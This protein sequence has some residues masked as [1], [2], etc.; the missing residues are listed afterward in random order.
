MRTTTAQR[1][2]TFV[3]ESQKVPTDV[4]SVVVIGVG[5]VGLPLAVRA[6]QKNLRVIGFDIDEKKVARLQSREANYITEEEQRA[7]RSLPN[8][9][10]TASES[11]IWHADCY[12]ICV[13]TPVKRDHTPDLTP[14]ENASRI[15]GA[16]MTEGALVVVE[17]TVNPGA[18]EEVALPIIEQLSG[19][20]AERDFY[21]AHCP[22]RV[23]PGDAKWNVITI[24]RVLG[25]S[26][27]KSLAAALTLYRLLVDADIMPMP[28]IKEAEAVKMV[29]N[30]FRDINIAFVNELAMSFDRAGLDLV[31][32]IRGASTKPFSFMPHFPG[33]GVGGHCIPVD[34]YYLIRYGEENGFE[35]SFL[36]TARNVNNKMPRYAVRRLVKT[37]KEVQRTLRGSTVALLG[38][39]YK[40]DV[41]DLRES[42]ALEIE[43]ELRAK[44]ANV[45]TFDPFLPGLSTALSLDE[46]LSG[47]D[48]AVI[49]TDHTMFRTL[50][51]DTFA[52]A[53]VS[54]VIDGRNCLSKHAF[55]KSGVV[56]RGIGR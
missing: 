18:C 23:N 41:P 20:T 47:A 5:Y 1:G 35:H 7:F 31:S 50:A 17:S 29:E 22:E 10:I 2:D 52:R 28:S 38:L 45:R 6:A 4:A 27:P 13:P 56:Y 36:K 32:V 51:P 39:A 33:C 49:A 16:H 42:P 15:V 40:K 37:L 12:I 3:R 14:L 34:P 24:P 44:G 21:Y 11:D 46:A 9:S 53:G 8:I 54:V 19:L 48:A 43:K 26:G 55:A 30:A 25:A